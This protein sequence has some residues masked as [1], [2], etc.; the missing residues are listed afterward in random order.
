M[1]DLVSSTIRPS[2]IEALQRGDMIPID[3]CDV[4]A[5]ELA[6]A[7][8]PMPKDKAAEMAQILVGSYPRHAV[9]A[10][11][12]Y[13]RAIVSLLVEYPAKIASAAID[14]VTRS[15]KFIPTR[16]EVFDALEMQMAPL[17]AL[18]VRARTMRQRIEAARAL[19]ESA[20]IEAQRVKEFAERFANENGGLTPLAFIS[21]QL[22][23]TASKGLQSEQEKTG[24]ENPD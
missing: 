16:A 21:Q 2:D 13:A 15:C 14:R 4:V 5:R 8:R 22:G 12:I 9:D 10:P 1:R 23:A 20:A 7:C 24:D 18:E 6:Q 17:R 19:E 3:R 11:E